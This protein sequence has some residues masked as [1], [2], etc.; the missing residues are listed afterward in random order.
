MEKGKLRR[1]FCSPERVDM[2]R[3][4]SALLGVRDRAMVELIFRGGYRPAQIAKAMGT[5]PSNV[6]R[7]IGK[8]VRRLAGGEYLT[9]LRR[10]DLFNETELAAARDFYL[11]GRSLSAIAMKYGLS[12]YGSRQLMS[13][14]EAKLKRIAAE[15]AA[16]DGGRKEWQRSWTLEK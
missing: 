6:T 7:R 10:R 8:I 4:R 9:C 15:N 16:A 5:Q 12:R 2:L 13:S 1:W 14:L 3:M 11:H